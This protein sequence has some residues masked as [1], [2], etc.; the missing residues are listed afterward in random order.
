MSYTKNILTVVALSFLA[1]IPLGASAAT[2][3]FSP[4]KV[5]VHT[6]DSFTVNVNINSPDATIYTVK[7]MGT[8]TPKIL[9]LSTWNY[10]DETWTV[11]R[12]PGY[13]AFSN[14]LG[15]FIRT[16]GVGGGFTGTTRFAKA[17][18]VAGAVGKGTITLDPNSLIYD[19]NSA[20]VYTGTNQVTVDVL[21]PVVKVPVVT[22]VV[23]TTPTAPTTPAP[24]S[25]DIALELSKPAI[26]PGE[27]M[28]VQVHLTNSSTAVEQLQVPVHYTITKSD[29]TV[30]LDEE[31]TIT[32]N[33]INSEFTYQPNLN[34]LPPDT[35]TLTASIEYPNMLQPVVSKA[36]FTIQAPT[37]AVKPVTV[38]KTSPYLI[39]LFLIIG[40]ICGAV[41]TAVLGFNQ[42]QSGAKYRRKKE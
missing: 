4:T 28:V 22:P 9:R 32:L 41:L 6:G 13:D 12:Q 16:A 5:S 14:T 1:L 39:V 29:G 2:I 11:L 7:A 30:V 20:N 42:K 24:P 38:Y 26:Q 27:P 15:T 19:S 23:P 18:F 17:T 34:N 10:D 21:P 35:Y 3:T 36:F 8:F 40:I 25:F 33:S 37:A 31:S